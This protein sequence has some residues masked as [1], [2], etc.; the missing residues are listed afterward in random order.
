M[1]T[2]IAVVIPLIT[3]V[4]TIASF[5]IGRNAASKNQGK[6]EGEIKAD[7]E[8]IKTR[9]DRLFLHQDELFSKINKNTER[10]S[11]TEENVKEAL[12]RIERLENK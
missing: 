11:R 1:E 10:L 7:I 5:L 6:Y 4:C 2:W 12:K 9:I 8:Y 3:A